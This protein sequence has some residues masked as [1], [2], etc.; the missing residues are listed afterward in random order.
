MY[1]SP[2]ISRINENMI[3]DI[4]PQLSNFKNNKLA[5]KKD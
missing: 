2:D 3:N 5:H 4:L 1:F